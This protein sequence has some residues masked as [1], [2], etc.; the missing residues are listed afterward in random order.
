[1]SNVDH[2]IAKRVLAHRTQR[3]LSQTELGQKLG[4]TFQQIQ[5]YEKGANRIGAGRLFEIAAAFN[6]PVEVLFPKPVELA[7][8]GEAPPQDLFSDIAF[9]A[10]GRRLCLAFAKIEDPKVRRKVV[11]LVEALSVPDDQSAERHS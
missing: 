10:E 6:I 2:E 1:M 5:K 3:R 11:A 4:V 9:T 7:E 8:N